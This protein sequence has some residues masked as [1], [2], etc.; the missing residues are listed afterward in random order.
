MTHTDKLFPALERALQT[1]AAPM[2][3][4]QLFDL[5]EVRKNA[6]SVARVSDYLGNL[7]RK[8]LVFRLPAPKG[9]DGRSR[10][11]YQWKAGAVS[12]P[13]CVEYTPRVIADRPTL[14]ITELGNVVT[15]EL[16]NLIISIRQK[17]P[18]F[19]YLEGL[20]GV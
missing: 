16:P 19:G 9:S 13:D 7:W 5:P 20:K 11:M 14:L 6:A 15:V 18:T 3:C 12:V 4:T 1:A 2:D 10:W 17:P 8:G